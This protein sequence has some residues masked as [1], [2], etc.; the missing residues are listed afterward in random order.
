MIECYNQKCKHHERHFLKEKSGPYC[1][2]FN[3]EPDCPPNRRR[4]AD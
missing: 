4:V 2:T 3:I 1:H